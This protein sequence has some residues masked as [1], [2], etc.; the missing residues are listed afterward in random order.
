[1]ADMS[2]K[3]TKEEWIGSGKLNLT[4]NTCGRHE[5][6]SSLDGE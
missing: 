3:R 1:M 5:D 4:R 6:N 2:E